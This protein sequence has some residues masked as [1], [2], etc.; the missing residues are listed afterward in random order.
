M[1][2][3]AQRHDVISAILSIMQRGRTHD[4]AL[5][6][7]LEIDRSACRLH[8]VKAKAV[9]EQDHHVLRKS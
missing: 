8:V 1:V 4:D 2:A 9:K 3:N 7:G 6:V 5:A